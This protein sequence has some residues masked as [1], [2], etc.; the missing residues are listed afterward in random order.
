MILNTN[1][2]SSKVIIVHPTQREDR[3]AVIQGLAPQEIEGQR[4]T[5][6]FRV[7]QTCHWGNAQDHTE[8]PKILEPVLNYYLRG[9]VWAV[10]VPS[11]ISHLS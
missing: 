7:F 11:V 2:T 5:R 8:Q 3:T 6:G 9:R 1:I 10:M 4:Q